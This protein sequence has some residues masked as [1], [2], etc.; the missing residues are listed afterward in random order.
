MLILEQALSRE[1]TRLM[2]QLGYDCKGLQ[3]NIGLEQEFFL[4]PRDSFARRL[5][6][7]MTGRTIMG[8]N[9]VSAYFESVLYV[10][11]CD[12]CKY[13]C[14]YVSMKS[15]SVRR[16]GWSRYILRAG[17]SIRGIATAI[18]VLLQSTLPCPD[19]YCCVILGMLKRG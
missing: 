14:M 17:N 10:P 2:K 13:A 19:W 1:G 8:K 4:I 18:L 5:D 9:A 6:L 11:G 16:R 12:S 7:Q 3:S 15:Q